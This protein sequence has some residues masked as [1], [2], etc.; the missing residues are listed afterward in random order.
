MKKAILEFRGK[1]T[2][3]EVPQDIVD[4][5]IESEKLAMASLEKYEP[6]NDMADFLQF[7]NSEEDEDDILCE[8]IYQKLCDWFTTKSVEVLGIK[9]EECSVEFRPMLN[10]SRCKKFGVSYGEYVIHA[11]IE[12]LGELESIILNRLIDVN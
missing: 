6:L 5:F 12:S 1:L 2:S 9:E 4:L 10:E 3:I 8:E 7:I 11:S